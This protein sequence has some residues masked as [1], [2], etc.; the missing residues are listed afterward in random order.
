MSGTYTRIVY[1]AVF[2][3]K[4]RT[5][6]ITPELRDRLHPYMGGVIRNEGG[7]LIIAGGMPDHVH[8]LVK[9]RADAPFAGLMRT[10]KSRSSRWVHETFPERS[11]FAWQDG[12]SAFTVSRSQESVVQ[13]YIERQEEHHRVRTF[14]EEIVEFLRS[15]GVEYDERYILG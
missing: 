2:S 13:R 5:P 12:Y 1:H 3:T 15:H 4:R 14:Q 8:L 11:D 7:S 10:V 9:W 6:W